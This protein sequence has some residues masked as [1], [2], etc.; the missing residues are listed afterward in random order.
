MQRSVAAW[1][2]AQRLTRTHSVPAR[3]LPVHPPP[4]F[5]LPGRLW[6]SLLLHYLFDKSTLLHFLKLWKTLGF[7]GVAFGGPCLYSIFLILGPRDTSHLAVSPHLT[8]RLKRFQFGPRSGP[9]HFRTE[10]PGLGVACQDRAAHQLCL[11][12]LLAH[13]ATVGYPVAAIRSTGMAPC[14]R[15]TPLMS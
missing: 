12:R 14:A 10:Q 5:P 8:P 15:M 11:Q 6:R 3:V 2:P 9:P 4:H 1:R 13:Q 7:A